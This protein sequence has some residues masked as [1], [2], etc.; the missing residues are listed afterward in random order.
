MKIAFACDHGGYPVKEAI[1]KML[2]KKDMKSLTVEPT[3]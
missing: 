2:K 1:I 3:H